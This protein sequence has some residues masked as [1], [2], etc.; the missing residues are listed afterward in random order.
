MRLLRLALAAGLGVALL[1]C[2][3]KTVNLGGNGAAGAGASSATKSD[4]WSFVNPT[5]VAPI[6]TANKVDVLLAIDNSPNMAAKA[7]MLAKGLPAFLGQVAEKTPDIH[8]GV[9]TS[10]LGDAGGDVCPTDPAHP[11]NDTRGELWK[12]SVATNGVLA[13]TDVSQLPT[14]GANAQTL[15][16]SVGQDGCGLEAQLES[17][18]RFLVQ[19]DPYDAVTLDT[20]MQA[21]LGAGI[22]TV[23][24]NDRRAFLRPD[25]LLVVLMLTDEDDSQ[26]DPMSTGGFGYAFMARDFPGSNVRRGTTAQGTTAP[27]GTSECDSN[28]ADVACTSCGYAENCD[29]TKAS[30][31]AINADPNCKMSP[32]A[33]FGAGFDGFYGPTDDDL[34]VRFFHMKQRFGIDP[35]FPIDR[36]LA[37][38]GSSSVPDRTAEHAI[39]IASN[40][41]RTIAD[42]THHNTCT[43]P[44]FAGTLPSAANEE[45]CD[46]PRGPR[47][48]DLV[49]FGLITGVPTD[50]GDAPTPNWVAISG[51]NP[52]AYDYTGID[53][54]MIQSIA[55]RQGMTGDW[56]TSKKDLQYACTFALPAP[57]VCGSN[58]Q[59]CDCGADPNTGVV[60]PDGLCDPNDLTT[61]IRGKAYPSARELRL[62]QGMGG[63]ATIGSICD[64]D[65]YAGFFARFGPTVQAKLQ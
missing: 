31:Q 34:N 20:F 19:P 53:E 36:Y 28:P 64:T 17:M 8:L 13:M 48:P 21:D 11:D 22:D 61:Q 49:M 39:A 33:E 54:R 55:Q 32:V 10:S 35:Q 4:T 18:Y 51:T 24:L 62:A 25:S 63:R 41:Q 27:R 59:S 43:N 9:I 26:A 30:C 45:L 2:D 15:V 58:S 57:L 42:Y 60:P 46:L 40:G 3:G 12:Q 44:L 37:G 23:L 14:F 47:T 29:K 56:D 38:F 16:R 52:G 6:T 5:N 1:N 7:E 50:L 65:N